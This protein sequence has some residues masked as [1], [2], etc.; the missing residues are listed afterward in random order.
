MTKMKM[1]FPTQCKKR[2]LGQN[3]KW[4]SIVTQLIK[5]LVPNNPKSNMSFSI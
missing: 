2:N 5:T 1:V 3:I 4:K